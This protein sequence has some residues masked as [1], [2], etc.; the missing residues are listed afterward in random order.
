MDLGEIHSLVELSL[1]Q[2][3]KCNI[4]T[5]ACPVSAVTDRFPGPKYEAPQAGRFRSNGQS[6]PDKSVD[7]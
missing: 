3:I 2:C 5:T 1:D 7:Y 6:S 4:C